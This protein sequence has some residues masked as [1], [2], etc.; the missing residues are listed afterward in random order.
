MIKRPITPERARV[1]AEELCARA[2]HCSGEI[3][4]K[5]LRWGLTRV[6]ADAIVDALVDTRFID[7]ARFARAFVRDRVRFAR[8]GRRKIAAALYQKRIDR[9]TIAEALDAIDPDEYLEAARAVVAAKARNYDGTYESRARIYRAAAA[10]G[11][12]P[13]IIS[14]AIAAWKADF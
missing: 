13:D 4:E 9:A 5:L 2:E 11:F 14:R 7:D 1:R 10:R 12:E 3:R 8:W 6:D